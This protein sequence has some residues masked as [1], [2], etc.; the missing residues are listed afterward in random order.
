[1]TEKQFFSIYVNGILQISAKRS[2]MQS[3]WLGYFT[4][5]FK[6]QQCHVNTHLQVNL[7]A[8]YSFHP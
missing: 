4:S 8:D 5:T 1:M 3:G 2:T 6:N 7:Y